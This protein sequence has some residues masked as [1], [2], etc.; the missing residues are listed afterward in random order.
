MFQY[1]GDSGPVRTQDVTDGL[2][3]TAAISESLADDGSDSFL[4]V[5]WR[6]PYPLLGPDQLEQFAHFCRDSALAATTT[7]SHRKGYPWPK[8]QP[9]QGLYNHVLLPNDASCF[10][11]SRVQQGAYSASSLHQGMV[12]VLF[13]D[14]HV[15]SESGQIDF[16]VWRALGSRN[17]G[18]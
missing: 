9:S 16:S 17:G 14:G 5:V 3:R 15:N 6:T 1:V 4:R 13:G 12:H 8:G 7:P 10:N 18:S 11:G 2:S